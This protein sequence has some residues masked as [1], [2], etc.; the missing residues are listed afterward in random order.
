[1]EISFKL[2][3]FLAIG[4]LLYTFIYDTIKKPLFMK[5]TAS[6]IKKTY[7]NNKSHSLFDLSV[8]NPS[9]FSAFISGTLG[10]IGYFLPILAREHHITQLALVLSIGL[11]ALKVFAVIPWLPGI[12]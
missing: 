5:N 11:A 10:Y 7:G 8:A 6:W 9:F 12:Y 1:M 3:L 2:F 4:V